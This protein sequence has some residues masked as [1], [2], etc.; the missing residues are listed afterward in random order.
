M[1]MKSTEIKSTETELRKTDATDRSCGKKNGAWIWVALHLMLAVLSFGT[2]CSKLAALEPFLS[3]RFFLYYGLL[4]L[5]LGVYALVWQQIIKRMSLT[6]A[7]A[8][9]AI[10]ILWGGLFGYLVFDE[11][12]TTGKIVGGLIVAAGVVLFAVSD[13]EKRTFDPSQT[14]QSVCRLAADRRKEDC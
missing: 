3:F 10:T 13:R 7:Y 11:K 12:I 5:I 6:A 14:E 2:V 9:R 8:N 1:K 4:I